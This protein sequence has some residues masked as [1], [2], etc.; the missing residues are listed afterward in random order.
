MLDDTQLRLAIFIG[1]LVFMAALEAILPK[2]ERQQTRSQRWA[3][4]LSLVVVNS[5][6]LKLLGPITAVIAADYALDNNWGLI[7]LSPIALPLFVE[8]LLGII[9]LDFAIYIQHVASHHFP[10]L[11]R[12]HKVHHA[13]R[14][15]DVTTGIRFHP[16][17][18]A[19][20][21][22]YKCGVILLLG[23]ITIAVIIFEILLNASAMFNHANIRLPN[24]LD[25]ILRTLI[26]TPDFHRVHHSVIE[27]ETNSNYGFFLSVWDKLCNTYIE[28]P[29]ENHQGMTIGL[30][31]YQNQNPGKLSW[32]LTVPFKN[33]T[34]ETE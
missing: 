14:D 6:V 17:E 10:I 1:V 31:A 28:Q 7:G 3:T 9:L 32:C 27:K 33:V 20:S 11:W 2:R 22:I 30:N 29:R 5:I 24:T 25:K 16:I 21:M 15:I 13:D 23:P 34:R 4:N 26:V 12:L 8:I 18:A 19:L